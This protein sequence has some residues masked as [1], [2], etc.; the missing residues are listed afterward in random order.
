MAWLLELLASFMLKAVSALVVKGMEWYSDH[1]AAV[2]KQKQIDDNLK[3]MKA[4]YKKAFDGQP[5]TADQR[6]DLK[7]AIRNFITHG[8]SGGL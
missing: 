3:L 6:E 8:T 5:M 4:A 2:A 1:E 7:S